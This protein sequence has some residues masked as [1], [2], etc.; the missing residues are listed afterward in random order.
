MCSSV[1]SGM[2]GIDMW[3]W[4]VLTCWVWS[5]LTCGRGGQ[6]LIFDYVFLSDVGYGWY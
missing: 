4:S 6:C 1:M 5:V 3:E 2:V